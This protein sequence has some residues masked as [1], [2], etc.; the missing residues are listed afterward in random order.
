MESL[1]RVVRILGVACALGLALAAFAQEAESE[2]EL[3][4]EKVELLH[5]NP[6]SRVQGVHIASR[7]A[8]P[9]LYE[10]RGFTPAWTDPDAREELLRAVRESAAD[11]LD[12]RT[13]C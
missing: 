1:Q 8:L 13:T 7:R 5:E 10:R 2:S 12:P 3:L 9:A 6:E 4:R 11:G